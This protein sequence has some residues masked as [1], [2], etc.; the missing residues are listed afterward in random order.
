MFK[1]NFKNKITQ[2]NWNVKT[3]PGKL[4]LHI[5]NFDVHNGCCVSRSIMIA[6]DL[7]VR[8]YIKYNEL[9]QKEL[10]WI[11][12]YDQKLG[13]WSQL[14]NLIYHYNSNEHVEEE[15]SVVDMISR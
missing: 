12:N 8:V 14:D 5:I 7:T 6:A 13:R 11:L 15:V 2:Y 4:L 9:Y 1:N 3:Y 10:N